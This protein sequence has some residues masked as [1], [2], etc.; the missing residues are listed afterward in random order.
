MSLGDGLQD[1][2]DLGTATGQWW[3]AERARAC[4]GGAS[5]TGEPVQDLLFGSVEMRAGVDT[6]LQ[7]HLAA[8]AGHHRQGLAP[9]SGQG[10]RAGVVRP[11]LSVERGFV[12]QLGTFDHGPGP[13]PG[14]RRGDEAHDT[15]RCNDW[16]GIATVSGREAGCAEAGKK[17]RHC[18][19]QESAQRLERGLQQV[20]I[21]AAV[22]T[23]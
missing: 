11:H 4:V 7:A 13:P 6:E 21:R 12:V 10:Q 16:F 2:A 19:G 5:P 3:V 20:A 9:A 14:R 18:A 15:C 22:E 1:A 23:R 8:D 17:L